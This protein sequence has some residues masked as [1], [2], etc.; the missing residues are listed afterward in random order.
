MWLKPCQDWK[1][2]EKKKTLGCRKRHEWRWLFVRLHACGG[3]TWEQEG[4]GGGG[5]VTRWMPHGRHRTS[6]PWGRGVW[7]EARL[8]V[9]SCLHPA[10]CSSQWCSGGFLYFGDLAQGTPGHPGDTCAR[11]LGPPWAGGGWTLFS[12]LLSSQTRSGVA[13]GRAGSAAGVV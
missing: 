4:A 13:G 11:G 9:W 7:E 5:T 3:R 1:Q 6:V 2:I 12:S 8:G 10:L